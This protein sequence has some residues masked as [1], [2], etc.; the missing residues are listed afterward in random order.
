MEEKNLHQLQAGMLLHQ[1]YRIECLLGAGGFGIT[2]RAMDETLKIPVAV[3]EYFPSQWV[4]RNSL[5][6]QDVILTAESRR[7]QYDSLKEKFLDEARVLAMF[8]NLRSVVRVR[9]FFYDNQ[10]A[11]IVMDYLDG[12]TLGAYIA[13]NGAMD[14]EWLCTMVIPMLRELD[15]VHQKG[16]I[17]RDISPDNIML[18]DSEYLELMDFGAA[19]SFSEDTIK[20]MSV[21]LKHGYAPYEQYTRHGRQGPWTDV[22]ALSATI[23]TC[24]TQVVPDSAT[25]RVED[26]EL[27][28]PSELGVAIGPAVEAAIL[29]GMSLRREERYQSAMEMADVLSTALKGEMP[30]SAERSPMSKK[31]VIIEDDDQSKNPASLLYGD[32]TGVPEK[33]PEHVPVEVP[34]ENVK[35]KPEIKTDPKVKQEPVPNKNPGQPEPKKKGRGVMAI[36]AIVVIGAV[37]CGAMLLVSGKKDMPPLPVKTAVPAA[38]EIK[39]PAEA[40]AP[41]VSPE[42]SVLKISAPTREPVKPAVVI[43]MEKPADAPIAQPAQAKQISELR[44]AEVGSEFIFGEYEQD[45]DSTNGKEPVA[46]TVLQIEDG[47]AMLIASKGLDSGILYNDDTVTINWEV[48]SLRKWLNG[49]FADAVFD[50]KEK[51]ALIRNEQGDKVSLLTLI[52]AKTFFADNVSRT[53]EP[54]AYAIANGAFTA[55]NGCSWWWLR[56]EDAGVTAPCVAAEGQ[57][58]PSISHYNSRNKVVRPVIILDLSAD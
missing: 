19:R 20:S 31:T 45:N 40:T 52:Q 23:Y 56:I 41:P 7:A 38:E 39:A 16:L 27:R 37:A 44:S 2:Y 51:K 46:W 33:K 57:V 10:T 28:K 25:D 5:V 36:A 34:Q 26:D 29:K 12:I 11:Y 14:P 22:Y 8:D 24:I 15:A 42:P 55:S 58:M 13:R 48:C 50:E 32:G 49:E 17:H 54:T 21:I 4:T 43:T 18:M 53:V 1:R 47:K 9:D 35:P 3:K 30:G 6:T